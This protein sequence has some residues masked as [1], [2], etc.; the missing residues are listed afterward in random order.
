M[1]F[2]IQEINRFISNKID[3]KTLRQQ[4]KEHGIDARRLS[5]F[6]QLALLGAYP[7]IGRASCRERV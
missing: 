7:E 6:T 2:Y 5:L 4:L 3:D 1:T